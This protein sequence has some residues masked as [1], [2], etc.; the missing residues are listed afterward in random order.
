M[1]ANVDVR[2][3]LPE[4]TMACLYIQATGD[5]IVPSSAA[6]D[7]MRNIPDIEIKR[8]SGPH[9]ILQVEPALSA[10]VITEFMESLSADE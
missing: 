1:L 8:I 10:A 5:R 6:V 2:R 9:P 3:F 7:F 4:L